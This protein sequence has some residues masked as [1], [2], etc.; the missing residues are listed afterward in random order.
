M[1][2]LI[3]Y[4]SIA[5]GVSFLCS[6]LEAVLL[7]TT[8]GYVH[9]LLETHPERGAMVQRVKT[10]LD[11]SLSTILT[12]NTFAHTMGAA[13]VGAT[14]LKVFG[15]QWESLISFVLSV[16]VLY[17]SEI[18]PKT[19]GATHWRGLIVPSAYIINFLSKILLPLNWLAAK[20]T[21]LF[22]S[23]K[24]NAMNRQEIAAMAL[25]GYKTGVLKQE[26]SDLV[27]NILSLKDIRTD[28]ITTPRTVVTAL[29][30]TI[31]IAEAAD[32]LK[33]SP[34]TRIPIYSDS[35]DHITGLVFNRA[36]LEA[37]RAGQGN[38]SLST[39]SSDAFRVSE[40]LPVLQLLDTFIKR[41]EHL[42]V[43]EDEFGQTTGIVTLEDATETLLGREIMD[44]HDTIEDMQAWAKSKYRTKL[45]RENGGAS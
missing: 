18:I 20:L 7:S 29:P 2:L 8:T 11:E 14:A 27:N 16:C 32:A 45:K 31:T 3:I 41:K 13:G 19:L 39:L 24:N 25:L 6:I 37:D 35:I 28:D 33:G 21:Q 43:V 12:L 36:V 26:E 42:F 5:L 44:E 9:N 1:T 10:R 17:F 34:F 4:L 23:K 22:K 38:D 15:N 40:Q 30:E